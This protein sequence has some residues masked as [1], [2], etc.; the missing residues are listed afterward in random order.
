M[1]SINILGN[2]NGHNDRQVIYERALHRWDLDHDD[3]VRLAAAVLRREV[4]FVPTRAHL[5]ERLGI[6]AAEL[7]TE[8]QNREQVSV[9]GQLLDL[10]YDATDAEREEFFRSVGPARVWDGLAAIVT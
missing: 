1:R 10:W 8:L 7:S 4:E 2:G 5:I 6:S 3:A 9:S